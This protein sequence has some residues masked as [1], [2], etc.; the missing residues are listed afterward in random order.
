MNLQFMLRLGLVLRGG[1]YI[2]TAKQQEFKRR[3]PME[4]A[5]KGGS[6]VY[7]AHDDRLPRPD[8]LTRQFTATD[9]SLMVEGR[10][11]NIF[12]RRVARSLTLGANAESA[13]CKWRRRRCWRREPRSAVSE[14]HSL[15]FNGDSEDCLFEIEH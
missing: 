14:S 12:Q 5:V 7:L 3:G 9:Q 2:Q 10:S 1:D 15:R 4:L 13:M 8:W 11:M 6:T